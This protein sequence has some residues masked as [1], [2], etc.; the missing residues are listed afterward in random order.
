[1][2]SLKEVIEKVKVKPLSSIHSVDRQVTGGYASDLLSCVLKGAKKD[3]VWV[4]LQSHLNVVAVASLLGLSGVI[5]TEG[6]LPDQET[7][8]KAENEGVVLLATPKTTFTVVGELTSLGIKGEV[9][10]P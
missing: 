6:N 4:T 2:I 7:L 3:T 8:T 10:N 1:M 5:I 9:I